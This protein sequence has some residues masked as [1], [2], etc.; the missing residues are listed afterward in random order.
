MNTRRHFLSSTLLGAASFA[1]G[2]AAA[3]EKGRHTL[4]AFTKHLQGLPFTDIANVAAEVGLDGIEAPVRP[5]GHVEPERVTEDLPKLVE[6]LRAKNL[7]L[8]ILTSGINQVSAEQNTEAV[9]RTAKALGVQ[10]FR[11]MYYKYDLKQPIEAQIAE[12]KPKIHDLI[13]LCSE[14]GIQPLLQNHSGRDYFGA[15]IWDAWSLMKHYQ[16]EQWGFA[17]DSYHTT[18]EAGMSW[19]IDVSLISTHIQAIYFKDVKWLAPGKA[20]GVPLGTGMVNKDIAKALLKQG[21]SGPISLHT[22]YM[23]G[24]ASKDPQFV[25][26]SVAA[27]K[28]DLAVMREWIAEA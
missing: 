9:L 3:P 19:P 12:W 8:T 7:E 1:S 24:D 10:R 15:P 28:R 5:G 6:A 27:F 22:E 14:I 11:M 18:V 26:D 21:F 13:Q 16:P 17:L 23:K 20:D 25:K 4:C 2:V